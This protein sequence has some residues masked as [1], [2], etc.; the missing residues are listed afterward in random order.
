MPPRQLSQ[1]IPSCA[2]VPRKRRLVA[3]LIAVP[4]LMPALAH[5]QLA[6][7]AAQPQPIDP[8]WGMQLAPQL[9]DHVLQPGQKPATFVLGDSTNGTTDQDMA[10]KGSAEV[11]RNTVVI[12][13]DALHYEQN[14][15]LADAYGQV[16]IISIV[17]T[18]ALPYALLRVYSS[19][20]CMTAPMYHFNVTGGSGSA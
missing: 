12:K 13:A 15:D 7:E 5:A 20:G 16:R 1:T 10:V 17:S 11:R 18:F 14:T 9:E 4:G 3:A 19:E 2:A 6:G 8:P